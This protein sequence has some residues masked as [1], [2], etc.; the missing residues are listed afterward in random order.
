MNERD[1]K[2]S[3]LDLFKKYPKLYDIFR[4]SIKKRNLILL[5]KNEDIKD[6]QI[7]NFINKD[8]GYYYNYDSS[9]EEKQS[10]EEKLFS[11]IKEKMISSPEKIIE[12]L[13]K[14]NNESFFKF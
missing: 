9:A 11:V 8:F 12:F 14:I 2:I 6:E 10:I 7:I 1:E 5:M 3:V 4:D 13:Q